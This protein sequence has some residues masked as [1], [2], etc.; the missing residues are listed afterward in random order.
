[1]CLYLRFG[2]P[3]ALDTEPQLILLIF[4]AW[5]PRA[6]L[7]FLSSE[8]KAVPRGEEQNLSKTKCL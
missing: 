6:V 2:S 3:C 1:M 5:H 4:D 7:T 8:S